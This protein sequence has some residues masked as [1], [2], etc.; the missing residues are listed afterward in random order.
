MWREAAQ[1]WSGRAVPE[2]ST[3]V[4]GI[5]FCH[6]RGVCPLQGGPGAEWSFPFSADVPT[7][8][9]Q[10]KG[11]HT[12]FPS[13]L[14]GELVSPA[15]PLQRMLGMSVVSG[16]HVLSSKL[17][18]QSPQE[19]RGQPPRSP[20]GVSAMFPLPTPFPEFLLCES[21]SF[22]LHQ[23]TFQEWVEN[24]EFMGGFH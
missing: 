16:S 18:V 15:S 19:R 12:W 7:A 9:Q 23:F 2:S 20:V 4:L 10:E 22:K 5:L 17:S 13:I 24:H 3:L 8:R 11:E 14:E 6:P 21:L 1:G